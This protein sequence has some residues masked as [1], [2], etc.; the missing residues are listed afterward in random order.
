MIVLGDNRMMSLTIV[1]SVY[2]CDVTKWMMASH[3]TN[4]VEYIL[5]TIKGS[6]GYAQLYPQDQVEYTI[7]TP[8]HILKDFIG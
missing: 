2:A 4:L 5:S 6:S 1:I 8:E 7:Y 3:I